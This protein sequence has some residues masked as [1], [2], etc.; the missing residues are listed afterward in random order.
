MPNNIDISCGNP[1]STKYP[2]PGDPLQVSLLIGINY[3][4]GVTGF[5]VVCKVHT[6]F[7]RKSKMVYNGFWKFFIP[8]I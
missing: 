6:I 2:P 3:G 5:N 1:T 4:G 7:L 8:S